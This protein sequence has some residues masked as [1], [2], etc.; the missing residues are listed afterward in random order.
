MN[1]ATL[2]LSVALVGSAGASATLGLP[3]LAVGRSQAAGSLHGGPGLVHRSLGSH[4]PAL[5]PSVVRVAACGRAGAVRAV[6]PQFQTALWP[7][8]YAP[9][10]IALDALAKTPVEVDLAGEEVAAAGDALTALVRSGPD[11]RGPCRGT[12]LDL[13]QEGEIRC[14]DPHHGPDCERCAARRGVCT[15]QAWWACL[16]YQRGPLFPFSQDWPSQLPAGSARRPGAP[17]PP[18][19]R[20]WQE[21]RRVSSR[22]AAG[23]CVGFYLLG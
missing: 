15:A 7:A 5:A 16:F 12:F 22:G 18:G 8:M 17:V 2:D 21:E 19:G 6:G 20:P 3:C 11:R 13:Q 14:L 4:T 1:E 23:R 9:D 10:G